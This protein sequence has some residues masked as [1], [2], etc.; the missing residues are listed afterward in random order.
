MKGGVPHHDLADDDAQVS[1]ETRAEDVI[2]L[3]KGILRTVEGGRVCGASQAAD[4]PRAG[5]AI[6]VLM[7]VCG[8]TAAS[9]FGIN[10]GVYTPHYLVLIGT[11]SS[12]KR[13][14][15]QS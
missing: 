12:T 3:C 7:L 4:S 8:V 10:V 1:R 5:A 14:R 6:R 11:Y 2:S 9:N 15:L 13:S